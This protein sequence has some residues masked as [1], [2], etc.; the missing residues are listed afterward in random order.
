VTTFLFPS[1]VE[2]N[3]AA[4][5]NFPYVEES[6][7]LLKLGREMIAV[8][9]ASVGLEYPSQGGRSPGFAICHFLLLAL[10]LTSHCK[11]FLTR[12]GLHIGRINQINTWS[13]LTIGDLYIISKCMQYRLLMIFLGPFSMLLEASS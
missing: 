6:A 5:E 9:P 1:V 8:A 11:V 3:E 4:Y 13:T 7:K 2:N 12:L 10:H